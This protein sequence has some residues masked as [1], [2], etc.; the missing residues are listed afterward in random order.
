M[1]NLAKLMHARLEHIEPATMKVVIRSGITA[2]IDATIQDIVMQVPTSSCSGCAQTRMSKP[3]F[4]AHD[5]TRM[6]E[7]MLPIDIV[8]SDITDPLAKSVCGGSHLVQFTCT[9]AK[10]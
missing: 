9:S 6:E 2:D 7:H 5:P 4:H 3:S 1:L 10:W 8:C